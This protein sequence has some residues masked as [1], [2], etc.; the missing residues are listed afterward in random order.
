MVREGVA[1]GDLA[2]RQTADSRRVSLQKDV[3][4][5]VDEEGEVDLERYTL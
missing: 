1:D 4:K 3:E 2:K 5:D